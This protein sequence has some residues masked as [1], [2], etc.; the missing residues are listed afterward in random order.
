MGCAAPTCCR[1]SPAPYTAV[2][3]KEGGSPAPRPELAPQQLSLGVAAAVPVAA[4]GVGPAARLAAARQRLAGSPAAAAALPTAA[5]GGGRPVAEPPDAA[6]WDL[7]VESS[8]I[9]G[10]RVLPWESSRDGHGAPVGQ[11]GLSEPQQQA[12]AGWRSLSDIVRRVPNLQPVVFEER[13]SSKD[14]QQGLV[15]DCSLICA[16]SALADYGQHFEDVLRHTIVPMRD[17]GEAEKAPAQYLCRL[18]FNG[19]MRA[20]VVDDQVPLGARAQLLCSRTS[21]PNELWVV[22]LEKA[23]AATLGGSYDMRGSNPGTD[24]FHLTGWIPENLDTAALRTDA[25]ISNAVF[26]AACQ[27]LRGGLCVVCLGTSGFDDAVVQ[28]DLQEEGRVEGVSASTGLVAGHAYLV[29]SMRQVGCHR[30]LRVKNP[31]GHIRWRGPM[32]PQDPMWDLGGE[33]ARELSCDSERGGVDDG[34][35]WIAWPDVLRHFSHVYVCWSPRSLGLKQLVLHGCWDPVGNFGSCKVCA[36]PDFIG[37]HPQARLRL[38]A[39]MPAGAVVWAVLSRHVADAH[40]VRANFMNVSIYRGC[41]RLCFTGDSLIE[42]GVYTNGECAI[43]KLKACQAMDDLDFIFVVNQHGDRSGLRFTLQVHSLVPGA[44]SWLLPLVA[45]G[46]GAGEVAGHWRPATAGGCSNS[47][48]SFFRNPQWLVRVPDAGARDVVAFA[49]C[50]PEHSL[51]LRIF[52]GGVATPE[53]LG[54]AVSSGAYRR[55]GCILRLPSV[56]PGLHVLIVS[57][58]HQNVCADYRLAWYSDAELTVEPHPHP[59][60]GALPHPLKCV[61]RVIPPGQPTWLTIRPLHAGVAWPTQVSMRL[62]AGAD[63]SALPSLVLWRRS[64]EGLLKAEA[65]VLP[66]DLAREYFES[67]GAV[68]ILGAELAPSETYMLQVVVSASAHEPKLYILSSSTVAVGN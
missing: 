5:A 8:C 40:D 41:E 46:H 18:F 62:Q 65:E 3:D 33:L 6:A 29:L 26:E 66:V 55:G 61:V 68:V 2:P 50:P 60:A 58:F 10:R 13:P 53:Q 36:A 57:T 1:C 51:N 19:C 37:G 16:L 43:V 34:C 12:F 9:F 48:W 22:L 25:G 67:F 39:P 30:V 47:V 56:P 52:R 11:I 49:E 45:R 21:R 20:I 54:V 17:E 24:L 28:A 35:F 27:G 32:G 59:F 7:A 23:V 15:S 4:P 44:L 38:G 42:Q 64:D 14:I 63:G 31:W